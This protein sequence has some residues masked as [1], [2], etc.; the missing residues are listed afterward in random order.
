MAV[1]FSPRLAFHGFDRSVSPDWQMVPV[2]STRVLTLAGVRGLVPRVR[3]TAVLEAV[4]ATR[5]GTTTLTLTGK[6]AGRTSVE[7]VPH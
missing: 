3:D 6:A 5:G 1:T 7:W 2:G 4:Q